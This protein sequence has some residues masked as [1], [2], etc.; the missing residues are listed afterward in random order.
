MTVVDSISNNIG[1]APYICI[2]IVLIVFGLT[3][4]T[5]YPRV[6]SRVLI[7]GVIELVTTVLAAA[8]QEFF[9]RSSFRGPGQYGLFNL[10]ISLVGLAGY[11]ILL[12][13]VFLDR[14]PQPGYSQPGY[15][16]AGYPQPGYQPGYPQPGYQ[17]GYPQPG[18]TQPPA[19]TQWPGQ[20]PQ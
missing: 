1:R 2:A 17:P 6:A 16:Q 11:A 3:K 12:S 10:F 4:A 13:A 19:A 7:A 5:V 15:P 8:A 20:P 18:P 9:Y 14:N